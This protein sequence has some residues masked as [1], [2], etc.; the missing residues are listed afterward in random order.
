MFIEKNVISKELYRLWKDNKFDI[1]YK[2]NMY[3]KKLINSSKSKLKNLVRSII[4]QHC[5]KYYYFAVLYYK[6]IRNI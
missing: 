5:M 1:D 6:K 3:Y 2:S 4:Y